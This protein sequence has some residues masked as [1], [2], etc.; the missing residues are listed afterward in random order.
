MGE[1]M[2]KIFIINGIILLSLLMIGCGKDKSSVQLLDNQKIVQGTVSNVFDSEEEAYVIIQTDSGEFVIDCQ[3]QSFEQTVENNDFVKVIVED[4]NV[5]HGVKVGI[6]F[7]II[8]HNKF[9]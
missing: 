4:I 7:S 2:K 3:K 9:E 5:Q 8:E 6:L 1:D